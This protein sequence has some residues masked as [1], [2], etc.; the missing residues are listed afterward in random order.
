MFAS[1]SSYRR[2]LFSE[3]SPVITCA[4]FVGAGSVRIMSSICSSVGIAFV[5]ISHCFVT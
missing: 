2:V 5:L 4:T 1:F 3:S